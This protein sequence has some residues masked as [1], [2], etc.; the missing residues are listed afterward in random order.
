MMSL[1]AGSLEKLTSRRRQIQKHDDM[2][3]ISM[4]YRDA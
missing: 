1:I 4:D 2:K 3:R